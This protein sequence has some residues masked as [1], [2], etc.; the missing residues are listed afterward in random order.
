M[1]KRA[2][3]HWE[4]PTANSEAMRKFYGGL[5]GWEF[6]YSENPEYW[7]FTTGSVGGGLTNVGD[8]TQPGDVM[9]YIESDDIEADLKKIEASGGKALM[10]PMEI[11]TVGWFATFSDPTGNTLALFKAMPM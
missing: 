11:P 1:G 5:F 3:V 4:L 2:I 6:Q 8:Y 7:G 9:L 10:P